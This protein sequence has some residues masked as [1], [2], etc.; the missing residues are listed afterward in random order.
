MKK[1]SYKSIFFT[2]LLMFV[3]GNIGIAQTATQILLNLQESIE[4]EELV[5][6]YVRAMGN[7]FATCIPVFVS[8]DSYNGYAIIS[9]DDLFFYYID[10]FLDS[11]QSQNFSN[12][13]YR[14]FAKNLLLQKDTIKLVYK[15]YQPN[16]KFRSFQVV[17][18]IMNY[19]YDKKQELIDLAFGDDTSLK[20]LD[21]KPIYQLG[22][23]VLKLFEW[24]IFM[25][26]W[27]YPPYY[28][29]FDIAFPQGSVPDVSK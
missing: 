29:L 26:D 5:E 21:S 3:L 6:R 10:E 28:R 16:W 4:K 8:S 23:I 25:M 22:S 24:G 11:V 1:K 19:S 2:L 12:E 17:D 7:G 18:S 27:D 14:T 9:G 13:D 20:E 15:K